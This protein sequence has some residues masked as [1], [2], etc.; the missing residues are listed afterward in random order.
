MT[1]SQALEI[2]QRFN[3]PLNV[4]FHALPAN[5]VERIIDAANEHKY[6]KPKNANGSRAR[7]F[8]ALLVRFTQRTS[9]Q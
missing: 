7:Y 4:D 8:H 1:Y 2:A 6:R 9:T 3:I 5:T